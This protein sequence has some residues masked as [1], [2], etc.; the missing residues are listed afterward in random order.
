[1]QYVSFE[2]TT[3]GQDVVD[4][5]MQYLGKPYSYGGNGPNSFDCSGFTKFVFSNFGVTLN[6]TA[7]DQSYN[8]TWVDRQNILPGDLLIF[9]NG[10]GKY[11]D[12]AGIYIGDNK[13]I[14]ASSNGG[15]VKISTLTDYFNNA[16]HSARRVI[17]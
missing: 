7:N 12:H 17:N 5:A 10:S 1:M 9:N 11:I 6:R 3:N 15:C 8:G 4:F 13:F 14:H 2:K 16:F